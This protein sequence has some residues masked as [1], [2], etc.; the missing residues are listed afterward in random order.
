MIKSFLR[1]GSALVFITGI[2]THITTGDA[3]S[4]MYFVLMALYLIH[5]SETL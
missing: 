3:L 5:V 4:A 2:A 1:Y